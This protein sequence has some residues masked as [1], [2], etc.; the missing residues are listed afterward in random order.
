[1]NRSAKIV[2]TIGPTSQDEAVLRHLIEAGMNIAR[3]NFSHGSHEDHAQRINLLRKLS[4]EMGTPI[5]ILQDLQG[6]RKSV[7]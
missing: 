2:A 1:M 5:T 4:R 6:D 7:V 3:L